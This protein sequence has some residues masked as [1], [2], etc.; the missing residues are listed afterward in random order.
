MTNINP[1]PETITDEII[2]AK[3][4]ALSELPVVVYEEADCPLCKQN[5][6]INTDHG[7]GKKYLEAK[8]NA[9]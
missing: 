1:N 5:I 3:Y 8:K 7:H 2:G 6:P 4:S 9:K